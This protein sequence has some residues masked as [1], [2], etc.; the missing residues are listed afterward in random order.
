MDPSLLPCFAPPSLLSLLLGIAF[1]KD[2]PACKLKNQSTAFGGGGT[3]KTH[4]LNNFFEHCGGYCDVSTEVKPP[5]STQGSL[6]EPT[7]PR[8]PSESAEPSQGLHSTQRL[9]L[10]HPASV[11]SLLQVRIP[12]GYPAC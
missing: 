4:F 6:E 3:R 10:P 2:V 8:A 7:S 11:P 9:P 12:A 1:Q 5:C